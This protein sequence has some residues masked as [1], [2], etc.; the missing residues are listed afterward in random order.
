MRH[1]ACTAA[2]ALAALGTAPAS[3]AANQPAALQECVD[4]SPNHEAAR[5]GTQYLLVKDGE[6]HFRIGL[7]SSCDAIV[8][9]AAVQ[10]SAQKQSNRLC[11]KHTR[12]SSRKGSCEARRVELI[13][14]RDF[15]RYQRNR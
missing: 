15:E 9:S 12:I 5:F 3:F 2:L 7:G 14:A 13:D 4:L 1:L 10:I 11:P 8:R 6:Q